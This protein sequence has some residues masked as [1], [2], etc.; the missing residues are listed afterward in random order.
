MGSFHYFAQCAYTNIRGR[1][2]FRK[3]VFSIYLN[4]DI[5]YYCVPTTCPRS[6][7]NVIVLLIC[8]YYGEQTINLISV[9]EFVLFINK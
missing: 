1:Y 6:S 9:R 4:M 5:F 7:F 2:T 3:S 8:L